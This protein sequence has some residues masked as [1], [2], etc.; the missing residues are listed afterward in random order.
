M[1]SDRTVAEAPDPDAERIFAFVAPPSVQA[2]WTP[3]EMV[4]IDGG[5]FVIGP[6][7][8]DSR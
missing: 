4:A 6:D 3:G 2:D 1:L 5:T 7:A 8:T